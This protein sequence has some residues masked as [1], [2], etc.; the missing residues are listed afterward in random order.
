VNSIVP[1]EPL[2]HQATERT[3]NRLV[4]FG[5]LILDN[6]VHRSMEF[7]S[8]LRHCN[9]RI[10]VI[11]LDEQKPFSL[12]KIEPILCNRCKF[13]IVMFHHRMRICDD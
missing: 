1:R 3:N 6:H 7:P 12:I 10:P 9:S 4:I 8:T 2:I 13:R 5:K 11:C